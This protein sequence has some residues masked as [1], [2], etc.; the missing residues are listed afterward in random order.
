MSEQFASDQ[1]FLPLDGISDSEVTLGKN[2]GPQTINFIP[3]D[4]GYLVNY[5]GRKD[6]FQRGD[7]PAYKGTPPGTNGVFS[8]VHVYRDAFGKTH[9]IYVR[10]MSLCVIEGNGF[11]ILH[12]FVGESINGTA[13]PHIFT[14]KDRLIVCNLGDPVLTWDGYQDVVPLGVTEIPAPP[15]VVVHEDP[16]LRENDVGVL[17]QYGLPDILRPDGFWSCVGMWPP[18]KEPQNYLGNQLVETTEIPGFYRW[19][20]VFGDRYG[21]RSV[22]SCPSPVMFIQKDEKGP[23]IDALSD[24]RDIK[25]WGLVEWTPPV[26]NP[27]IRFVEVYRTLNLHDLKGNDPDVYYREF[28]QT[29]IVGHRYTSGPRS[30]GDISN[31]LMLDEE[32]GPP[33]STNLGCS[34][35]A[36]IVL[37]DPENQEVTYFSDE[38]LSGMFRLSTNFYR[39]RD[40]VEAYVPAGD[41]ILIITNTTCEV[42]Y[43]DN[44]G[45]IKLL[46]IYENKG[47]YYGG[48]FA[49][50]R[51]QVFGFFNDGFFMFDG[52]TFTK[53]PTPYF[54]IPEHIDRHHNLQRAVIKGDWYFLVV[55]KDAESV[56]NN[57]MMINHL[58]TQRWYIVEESVNDI[59]VADEFILGADNSVYVL[60]N[61]NTYAESI[62]HLHGVVGES[63]LEQKTLTNVGLIMDPQS[64]AAV[65]LTIYSDDQY[66]ISE[67]EGISYPSERKIM[68]DDKPKP[69]WNRP[70]TEYG[71]K[72]ISPNE[73]L[74]RLKMDK[75]V[76]GYKHSVEIKFAAG[77]PQ[78][79][80]AA[81][82]TMSSGSGDADQR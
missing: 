70:N 49:T 59:A 2:L 64:M 51:D 81:I 69:Y 55:R 31:D 11:R 22:A 19:V 46:E 45:N 4:E 15:T 34:W 60:F 1:I 16:F 52:S 44:D 82:L 24:T 43:Q 42:L 29:N 54:L 21:N 36:R 57:V 28:I 56:N 48:T 67:G 73:T 39:S 50:F 77:L 71:V 76:P 32:A 80:R 25:H 66:D 78:R 23:S 79:V 58:P 74:V 47:S 8:R 75:T 63:I 53:V 7:V 38:A 3:D 9:I 20:I 18:G 35:G 30:D 62:I 33:K 10:G 65:D 6:Y 37:R 12:T 61:G 14:H 68:K 17:A 26:D 5:P 13:W 72:W 40:K 27:H 41:R